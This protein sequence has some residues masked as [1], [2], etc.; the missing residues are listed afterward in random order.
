MYYNVF[1]RLN[2]YEKYLKNFASE[3]IDN[4]GEKNYSHDFV[5]P[6]FIISSKKFYFIL[7]NRFVL[8]AIRVKFI[9]M[10]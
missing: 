6:F 2:Y 10:L 4:A 8:V 9:L 1:M 5:M 3:Y 7:V